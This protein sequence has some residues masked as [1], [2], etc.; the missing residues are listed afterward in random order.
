MDA[1]DTLAEVRVV[2]SPWRM[3]LRLLSPVLWIRPQI[4]SVWP[5]SYSFPVSLLAC[6]RRPSMLCSI[7]PA[8]VENR[9]E[10]RQSGD[11]G[12]GQMTFGWA[13][14]RFMCL[15]QF[16]GSVPSTI[17]P[18][19]YSEKWTI[20][21]AQN[22]S[23]WVQVPGPCEGQAGGKLAAVL[24]LWLVPPGVTPPGGSRPAQRR[25]RASSRGQIGLGWNECWAGLL[26]IPA[27]CTPP[28]EWAPLDTSGYYSWTKAGQGL[29]VPLG[30]D[31]GLAVPVRWV[32]LPGLK[33][34]GPISF[35]GVL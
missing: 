3:Y 10:R 12:T 24:S 21:L 13:T 8:G 6:L 32:E 31:S 19:S 33:G 5:S 7:V 28:G 34:Q 25:P 14:R 22:E 27:P 20:H 16:T 26:L 9:A 29:A 15:G 35:P 1:R 18:L 2:T 11:L 30:S 4:L 23:V 17:S